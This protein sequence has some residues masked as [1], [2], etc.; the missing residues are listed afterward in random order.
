M[1]RVLVAEDEPTT[2]FLL[3]QLLRRQGHEVMVA[4]DGSQALRLDE[5]ASADLIV[6]DINMPEMTGVELLRRI[7]QRR[8]EVPAII[9]SSSFEQAADMLRDASRQTLFIRKPVSDAALSQAVA[10]LMHPAA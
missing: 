4:P 2:A 6:T 9:V 1:S 3:E 8:P 10:H 5:G 7:R